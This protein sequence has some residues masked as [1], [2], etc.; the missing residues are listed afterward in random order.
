MIA[1]VNVDPNP[2]VDG[3]HLYELRI[4]SKVITTF[5]H[6]RADPLHKCLE[7]A[8]R[9]A[10]LHRIELLKVVIDDNY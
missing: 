8:A 4:N 9:A 6:D 1:I 10:K 3:P 2:R 5:V 7:R